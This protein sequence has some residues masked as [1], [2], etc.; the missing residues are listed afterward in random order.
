MF[1]L[2]KQASRKKWRILADHC[3]KTGGDAEVDRTGWSIFDFNAGPL[4]KHFQVKLSALSK[5]A[6]A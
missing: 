4:D 6:I 2:C 5:Y 1:D 3:C